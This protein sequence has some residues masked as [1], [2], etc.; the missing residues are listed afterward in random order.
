[1]SVPRPERPGSFNAPSAAWKAWAS[2]MSSKDASNPS[3]MRITCANRDRN[4]AP[5]SRAVPANQPSTTMTSPA[6][7][8]SSGVTVNSLQSP[9]TGA[10]T[11]STMA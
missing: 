5:L 3:R 7:R 2:E 4:V 1:M 8:Y 10:T 11:L 9:G 6:S